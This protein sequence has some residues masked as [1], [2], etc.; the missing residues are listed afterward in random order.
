MRRL[1]TCAFVA[2]A[3]VAFAA[4]HSTRSE[5]QNGG[6]SANGNCAYP[7]DLITAG[8]ASQGKLGHNE[9]V[10]LHGHALIHTRSTRARCQSKEPTCSVLGAGTLGAAPC[11]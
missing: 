5:A 2:L 1:R 6:Q 9:C 8:K 3:F 11:I 7:L 4:F 10:E